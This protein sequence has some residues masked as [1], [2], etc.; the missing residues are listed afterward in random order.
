MRRAVVTVSSSLLLL[1]ACS[2]TAPQSASKSE[3]VLGREADVRVEAEIL[4]SAGGMTTGVIVRC[5]VENLRSEAIEIADFSSETSFDPDSGVITV[6]LGSELPPDDSSRLVTL[7]PNEKRT[8]Q[9]TAAMRLS[10]SERR[11]AR[12]RNLV[13]L[14][15]HFYDRP[16]TA[17]A[18][19]VGDAFDTWMEAK[20][21][22]ITN[23]IPLGNPMM[24]AMNLTDA[25]TRTPRFPGRTR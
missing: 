7:E 22:V 2:S 25:S 19:V 3:W 8:F 5:E 4:P 12:I 18:S 24:P 9:F 6:N 14:K 11:L 16:R 15:L 17:L 13:R 23:A 21:T 1:A 20:R 10:S